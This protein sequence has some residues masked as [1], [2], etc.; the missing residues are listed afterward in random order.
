M[1]VCVC[2]AAVSEIEG[3]TRKINSDRAI[4]IT[5]M[6]D[7]HIIATI[8]YTY[9]HTH[10][11]DKQIKAALSLLSSFLPSLARFKNMDDGV[12]YLS[13]HLGQ[14]TTALIH[15]CKHTEAGSHSLALEL[16]FM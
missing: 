6:N 3:K 12:Q 8:I 11:H 14:K 5:T 15:I 10:T 13:I 1:C 2:A 16:L 4:K 9:T 7:R